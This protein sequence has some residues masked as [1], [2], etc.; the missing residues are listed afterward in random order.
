MGLRPVGPSKRAEHRKER[1][2]QKAV[3]GVKPLRRKWTK[4]VNFQLESLEKCRA[5]LLICQ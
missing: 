3:T 4:L 5:L 1:Y 2:K